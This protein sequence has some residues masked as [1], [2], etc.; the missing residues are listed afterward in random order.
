MHNGKILFTKN[1]EV[2]N[3]NLKAISYNDQE[4]LS[5]NVERVTSS[6]KELGSTDLYPTYI[7]YSPNG[8][9]F[10]I[11]NTKEFA[12]IK[13][14]SFKNVILGNGS[15]LTWYGEGDFVVL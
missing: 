2:F 4:G 9:H 5:Y 11:C 10:G 14:A 13:I 6:P 12:V 7:N 3:T 1:M 8:H 15:Q